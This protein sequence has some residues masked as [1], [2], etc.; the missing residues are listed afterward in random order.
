MRKMIG[1]AVE[2]VRSWKWQH[3]LA[4]GV[5]LVAALVVAWF[6]AGTL[7]GFTGVLLV[8][9]LPVAAVVAPAL[10]ATVGFGVVLLALVLSGKVP[11][12]PGKK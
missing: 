10:G 12:A 1:N 4:Y 2:T 8:V 6:G 7:Q 11:E 5:S 9:V 3:W